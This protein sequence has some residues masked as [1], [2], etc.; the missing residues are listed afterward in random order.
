MID[1]DDPEIEKKWFA[2]RR[3]EVANYLEREG[4]KHGGIGEEPAWFVAPYVSIWT[5]ESQRCPNSV[6]WWA[7]SGDLPTDYVSAKNIN[8]PREAVQAI[9]TLWQEASQYMERGEKHPT[10][11]IGNGDNDEELGP[12]LASRAEL[13]LD[14]VDDPEAWVEESY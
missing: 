12:M 7:I 5:V 3:D 2:I 4:V 11:S 9:A 13:L 6:G 1:Y 10:F 14:W 8:N